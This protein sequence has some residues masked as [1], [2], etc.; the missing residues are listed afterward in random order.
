ML[1][2]LGRVAVICLFHKRLKSFRSLKNII[3]D[4]KRNLFRLNGEK[5]VYIYIQ[6][7]RVFHAAEF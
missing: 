1:F 3:L 5:N 7:K 6:G 4:L 2:E